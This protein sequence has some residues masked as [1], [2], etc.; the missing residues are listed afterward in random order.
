M[1]NR[2]DMNE[3][4][5]D[6]IAGLERQGADP[7]DSPYPRRSIFPADVVADPEAAEADVSAGS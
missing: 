6:L 4:S 3:G 2:R 1:R 7:N 5:W